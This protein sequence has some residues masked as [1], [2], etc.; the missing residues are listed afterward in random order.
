MRT[1]I[2]T[3][4]AGRGLRTFPE[5]E[6][7][8]NRLSRFFDWPFEEGETF[9]WTPTVDVEETDEALVL[10]AEMPGLEAENVE[11]EVEGNLLTLSGE[12]TAERESEETDGRNLRVWERRY[13][14]FSRSFTLPNAVEADKI[15]ADFE[16]GVLTIRMPKAAEAK[17]RRIPVKKTS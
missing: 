1:L 12:K 11:I 14:S 3:R 15:K 10:T 9:G 7:T 13:G 16:N 5:F 2:P 8:E 6:G 17:G 4:W